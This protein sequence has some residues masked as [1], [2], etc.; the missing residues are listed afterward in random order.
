MRRIRFL[1]VLAATAALALFTGTA[2]ASGPPIVNETD[3]VVNETETFVSGDPCTGAPAEITLVQSGIQHVTFF[4]DGTAHLTET[5]RGTF[6][7]R[8]V[9]AFGNPVGDA[10]ATGSFV[11]SDSV[12]G[13]FDLS[14]MEPIGKAEITDTL[15]GGGTR[16]DGT[17]FR[18]HN[19]EH[20]LLTGSP[21]STK[22]EFFKAHCN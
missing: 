20:I 12:N 16:T 21:P 8:Q 14:T 2:F 1:F 4:A 22:L 10:Y 6:A 9:D 18:F 7:F 13:V 15:N 3:H 5:L 19:N 17:S 11:S